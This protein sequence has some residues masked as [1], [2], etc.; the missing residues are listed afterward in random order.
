[1]FDAAHTPAGPTAFGAHG[2]RARLERDHASYRLKGVMVFEVIFGILSTLGDIL[3]PT[4]FVRAFWLVVL[5]IIVLA[6]VAY[7]TR[8]P[9]A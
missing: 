7:F 3:A 5:M 9:L 2:H 1:M 4:P 8:M 6:I